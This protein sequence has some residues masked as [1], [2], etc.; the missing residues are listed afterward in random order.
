M[1][2]DDEFFLV[3]LKLNEKTYAQTKL[4]E[5]LETMQINKMYVKIVS[6]QEITNIRVFLTKLKSKFG[7]SILTSLFDKPEFQLF[8]VRYDFILELEKVG[9]PVLKI[10]ELDFELARADSI[11]EIFINFGPRAE[12]TNVKMIG[13][14]LRGKYNI[15][16]DVETIIQKE[17]LKDCEK[18]NACLTKQEIGHLI[19]KKLR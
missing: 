5:F 17:I 11:E 7:Q 3:N 16:T 9:L 14:E 13:R 15:T 2:F 19:A 4:S 12:S 10:M 6:N 1:S 18:L 8:E